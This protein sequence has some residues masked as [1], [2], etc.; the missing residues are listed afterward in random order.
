LSEKLLDREPVRRVQAALDAI[1]SGAKVIVLQDTA[2]TAQDAAN[3]LGCE[4]G[5]IVKSLVFRSG[6][7]AVMALIAGDR[8]CDLKVL[9]DDL[10]LPGKP[11]RAD[12][13]FVQ[14]QTG[15][16]IGSVSPLGHLREIPLLIDQSMNR[17]SVLYAA[18]GHP[19]CV[20]RTNLEELDRSTNGE[21]SK[22]VGC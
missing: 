13:D 21:L 6:D 8:Q 5:A 16:S 17:F 1:G 4:L 15:F 22:K 7:Q 18:A 20:Y 10:G 14:A 19:H 12:A 11:K 2:R 9:R 3:T